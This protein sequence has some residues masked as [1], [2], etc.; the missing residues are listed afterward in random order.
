[1]YDAGTP[2]RPRT[3]TVLTWLVAGALVLTAVLGTAWLFGRDGTVR[4]AGA[5]ASASARSATPVADDSTGSSP[6][7]SPDAGPSEEPTPAPTSVPQP[8]EPVVALTGSGSGR[9]LDVPG[10]NLADGAVLQIYDCNGSVAQQWTVTAA[11]ELRIGGSVCLE[12]TS[13]GANSIPVTLRACHG[14]T[15]QR[16]SA[17]GDGSVRN[18]ATGLCLDVEAAGTENGSPVIV[19]ECHLGANQLW[20]IG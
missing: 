1:M 7:A 8:Q 2:A 6:S 14:G 16:W 15:G 12:D 20:T 3:G 11:G 10:A 18:A 13:G 17:P 4:P 5:G 9:C 19:Y